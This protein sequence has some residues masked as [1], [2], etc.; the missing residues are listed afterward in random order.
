MVLSL[1]AGYGTA[2]LAANAVCNNVAT[3]AVLPGTSMGFAVLTV[4]AQ[5]VGAGDFEQVKYYTKRLIMAAYGCLIVMNV[6]VLLAMPTVLSIYGLSDEAS[7]YAVK[8]LIYHSLCVVTI[9]P[10]SF[11]LPNALRAAADVKFTMLCRSF[12]CG[13]SAS[14]SACFWAPCSAWASSASGLP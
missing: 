7:G 1:V 6:L 11:T 9:W 13:S 5:C 10:M 3:F 14:A 12:P 8:I 2:S 4:T